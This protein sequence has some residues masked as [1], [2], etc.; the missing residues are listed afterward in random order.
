VLWFLSLVLSL[1]CALSATLMQQWARRYRELTA[2][3]SGGAPHRRGRIQAYIS[4]GMMRFGFLAQAVVP[5]ST[6]LHISV[7]LFFAGLVEFLFPIY[8][9]IAYTTLVSIGIFAFPYAI[10]T[11]LPSFYFNCP[12]GTPLSGVAWR[13]SQ[14]SQFAFLWAG[15]KIWGLFYPLVFNLTDRWMDWMSLVQEQLMIRRRWLSQG[16]RRTVEKCAYDGAYSTVVTRA[17]SW[18]LMG[19]DK[20]KEVENF[21]ARI[22]GFFDSHVISDPTSAILPLMS[23]YIDRSLGSRLYDLLKTCIPETSDLDEKM[24]IYRLSVC[25]KCLWYFGNAYNR[26]APVFNPLSSSFPV[27]LAGPEIIRCVQA[28]QDSSIR[29]LGRCFGALIANKL[30]SDIN[31]PSRSSFVPP[32]TVPSFTTPQL[33]CLSAILAIEEHDV[34]LLLRKPGSVAI[35]NMISLTF[36][37]VGTALASAAPSKV[38]DMAQQTLATLS[39]ALPSEDHEDDA[40]SQLSQ[41][42][43]LI[44][45]SDRKLERALVSYFRGLGMAVQGASPLSEEVRTSCLRMCLKGLWL[46][47]K[48]YHDPSNQFLPNSPLVLASPAITHFS[49]TEHPVARITGRCFGALIVSKLVGAFMSPNPLS[50]ACRQRGTGLPHIVDLMSLRTVKI[51]FYLSRASFSSSIS[52]VS[53]PSCRARSTPYSLPRVCGRR[54]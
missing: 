10:L 15:L 17:L 13:I 54:S 6:L 20:D 31:P 36:G 47:G 3:G 39:R 21:V 38:R 33:A 28:E 23:D 30:A 49:Q 19:L 25:V 26:E 22:P 40:R 42:L 37:E 5:I 24:R 29:V 48:A 11:I 27:T 7:F 35:A 32:L 12:F 8:T 45:G 52:G 41:P 1:N 4:D 34:A 44:V 2:S 18:T 53:F 16:Q 50:D 9:A 51:H 14:F 46:C 43:A